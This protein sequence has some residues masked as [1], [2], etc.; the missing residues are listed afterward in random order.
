MSRRQR[1]CGPNEIRQRSNG[2]SQEEGW[3]ILD[4][5][6]HPS[7]AHHNH[8][9][10]VAFRSAKVALWPQRPTRQPSFYFSTCSSIFFRFSY[11]PRTVL[12]R[13]NFRRQPACPKPI[14]PNSK[15]LEQW[16]QMETTRPKTEF[17]L[18]GPRHAKH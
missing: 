15:G 10:V 6:K 11:T 16:K 13:N 3:P 4:L 5:D 1:D 9:R 12:R 8:R 14:H 7:V 2:N 17:S 18:T